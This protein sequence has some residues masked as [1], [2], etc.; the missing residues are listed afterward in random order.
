MVFYATFNNILVILVEETGVPGEN[1]CPVTSNLQTLSYNV[2]SST[3]T[4]VLV[5][6][7]LFRNCKFQ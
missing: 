5:I 3:L 1:H 4:L 6:I 2:T 7:T